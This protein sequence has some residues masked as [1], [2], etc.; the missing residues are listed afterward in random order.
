MKDSYDNHNRAHTPKTLKPYLW[1]VMINLAT[2][3]FFHKDR[4]SDLNARAA[5]IHLL[6]DALVSLGVVISSVLL[7]AS[8][9]LWIDPIISVLVSLIILMHPAISRANLSGELSW[10]S[11][12]FSRVHEL[13][14][15]ALSTHEAALSAHVLTESKDVDKIAPTLS[16]MLKTS[17]KIQHSTIQIEQQGGLR[18]YD[19]MQGARCL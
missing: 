2:A 1:A 13:P 16:E 7:V 10:E 6:G 5:F 15:W 3:Y 8:G 14:V 18:S 17:F 9:R 4:H 19:L 11:R 12:E